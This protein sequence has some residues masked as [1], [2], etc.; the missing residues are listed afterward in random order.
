MEYSTASFFFLFDSC[1]FPCINV[2]SPGFM[3]NIIGAKLIQIISAFET[4]RFIKQ[5]SVSSSLKNN[6]KISYPAQNNIFGG[7]GLK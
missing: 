5:L 3:K 6:L 4:F 2:F 7:G 1:H